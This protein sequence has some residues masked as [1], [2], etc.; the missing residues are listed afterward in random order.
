MNLGSD[1]KENLSFIS[2][3]VALSSGGLDAVNHG[4]EQTRAR[5]GVS[6]LYGLLIHDAADLLG[7]D[8]NALWRKLQH[9]KSE[10]QVNR[11]GVSVYSVDSALEMSKRF[12]L[13]IIQVPLS[14]FDQ[15]L[16]VDDTLLR[17]KES[18]V[19]VHAR[20]IFLQGIIL[21]APDDLPP[22]LTPARAILSRYHQLLSK[23]GVTPLQ[24]ALAFPL[25]HKAIDSI[26]LGI[27]NM[28]MLR[29]I[30]EV[31]SQPLPQLNFSEFAIENDFVC[32]PS[33]WT[34]S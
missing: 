14:I 16:V 6:S 24:A 31:M 32:N 9:F 28:T 3:T 12:P 20:S 34:S 23:Y 19:E 25:T 33:A 10:G 15:R 13:D 21:S 18:G 27:D 5:L 11:I 26:V 4:F 29:Q 2:K 17:L 8:G 1:L 30:I 22:L 7:P